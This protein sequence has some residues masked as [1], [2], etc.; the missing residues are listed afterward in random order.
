MPGLVEELWERVKSRDLV[1]A[2]TA[3]MQEELKQPAFQR[4]GAFIEDTMLPLMRLFSRYFDGEV[5]GLDK[6]PREGGALLVGNHSGGTITPDTTVLLSAFYGAFGAQRRLTLL[7]LDAL[8]AIPRFNTLCRKLG[9]V[10][11][12]GDNAA[13]ALRDGAPVLVYPGG[14]DEAFRPWTERNRVDLR[15]RKGFVRLALSTGVPVIPIVA[16]GGHDTVFVLS[17]GEQLAVTMGMR[18]MRLGIFPIVLQFPWGITGAAPPGLPLPSK[19]TVQVC[20]PLDWSRYGPEGARDQETVDR[21]YDE[22][23]VVMQRALDVLA[24][25]RPRPLL[26][27]LRRFLPG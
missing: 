6:I 22:I 11:A 16:H 2:W 18:R 20:D 9:L 3:Q 27:G 21:C 23:S 8:F 19:I 24:A 1:S 15:G 14:A 26:D 4:D 10:P 13:R 17:R 5:R 25:E 7:A 12:S